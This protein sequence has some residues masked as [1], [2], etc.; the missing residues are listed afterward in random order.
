MKNLDARIQFQ[1]ENPKRFGSEGYRRYHQYC[2]AKTVR[3]ALYWGAAPGDIHHDAAAG[4]LTYIPERPRTKGSKKVMVG[5]YQDSCKYYIAERFFFFLGIQARKQAS[6]ENAQVSL[7]ALDRVEAIVRFRVNKKIMEGKEST[8]KDF[9]SYV[10]AAV[11]QVQKESPSIGVGKWRY[12]SK[13]ILSYPGFTQTSLQKLRK[14]PQISFGIREIRVLTDTL[15]NCLRGW[16]KLATAAG[17]TKLSDIVGVDGMDP[18]R[19][20]A[21]E[22]AMQELANLKKGE[23]PSDAAVLKALR[24]WGFAKSDS[25]PNV[26]PEGHSWVHSDTLGVIET[27]SDH[28]MVVSTPCHGHEHFMQLLCAWARKRSPN[29]ELPFT[30]ISL[31]K[32]YAGKM[33]RDA[34]NYGPSIGLAIGPFTGGKLRYWAGDSQKGKRSNTVERVRAEPSLALNIRQGVV[35]DGNCAHEVEPF[36]GERYSLIFFT[37]KKYKK[38]GHSV[39]RKMMSMGADWPTT[40]SLKRLRGNIPRL[41]AK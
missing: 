17:L 27:R 28:T 41:A 4:F 15:E 29:G 36:K 9:M 6:I 20:A 8:L 32:N 26:M 5:I 14:D 21:D 38:T 2:R 11:A 40:S 7:K 23:R 18:G 22:F 13:N 35:F 1:Q 24:L 10:R 34:G 3:E 25:R 16:L 31:N 37:V 19:R 39:K 30:T 33:H 12:H